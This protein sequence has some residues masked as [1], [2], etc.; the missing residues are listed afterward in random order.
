MRT[1]TLLAPRR[2]HPLIVAITTLV[3]LT[4]M[5]VMLASMG[6]YLIASAPLVAP[7]T[8]S[9]LSRW[10]DGDAST[11]PPALR[12][13]R[14]QAL[15]YAATQLDTLNAELQ[16]RIDR[17]F[18][19]WYFS[20][21][22]QVRLGLIG[23]GYWLADTATVERLI[24][25]QP[26]PRE[27][28]A[29]LIESEFA[30]RVI[31]PQQAGQQLKAI[32]QETQSR[33]LTS[34]QG[35]RDLSPLSAKSPLFLDEV[36]FLISVTQT[37]PT[38]V[39]KTAATSGA[40]GSSLAATLAAKSGAMT[41]AQVGAAVMGPVLGLGLIAWDLW[42]HHQAEKVDRPFLRQT[43]AVYLKLV[44]QPLLHDANHG[45]LMPVTAVGQA[46]PAAKPVS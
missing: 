4:V 36:S 34:L 44:K 37:D 43:L 9:Q 16:N 2:T 30:A 11:T 42:D 31:Q 15:R 33:Y 19:P 13:A 21:P 1:L 12:A 7:D 10:S 18:L 39:V 46:A 25:P 35:V 24:G 29:A 22:Q 3:W 32:A 5:V 26:N 38:S 23:L 28:M 45:L 8:S 27:R 17:D 20:Y 14:E 6:R 41:G 40:A